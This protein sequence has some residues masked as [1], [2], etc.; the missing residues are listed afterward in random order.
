M[1]FSLVLLL[2]FAVS[3]YGGLELTDEQIKEL[4][5]AFSLFD[6]DDTGF[7]T[8]AGFQSVIRNLG[9]NLTDNDVDVMFREADT[10][11]DGQ[12]NFEDFVKIVFND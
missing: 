2:V 8:K 3:V 10:D 11:G 7:I 6:K 12:I 5:E 9:V 1:K 4:K